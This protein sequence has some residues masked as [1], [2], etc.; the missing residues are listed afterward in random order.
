MT[1]PVST[2][3]WP[4]TALPTSARTASS[5]LRTASGPAL[6][7][8]WLGRAASPAA[9][10]CSAVTGVR[11]SS[12]T[13]SM[14][15]PSAT[16]AASSRGTGP[17]RTSRS[18]AG[19]RPVRA[20]TAAHTV[21]GSA[22]PGSASRLV[23]RCSAAPRSTAG[24]P[25]T[26]VPGPVQP[27][28]A[29]HRFR[30]AHDDRERLGDQR[31]EPPHPPRRGQQNGQ[32]HLRRDQVGRAGDLLQQGLGRG[33]P[34]APPGTAGG[35]GTSQMIRRLPASRFSASAASPRL[36]RSALLSGCP[37]PSRVTDRPADW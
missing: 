12:S 18:L 32:E 33:R 19:S 5:A 23:I 35:L 8:P 27:A 6:A 15:R 37:L 29:F 16:S 28:M 26:G 22:V 13:A 30:G 14:S 10:G 3:S 34:G 31:P 24:G 4:T 9:G 1:R 7:A 11:T 25:V 21:S 36:A 20:D 17:N 2:E